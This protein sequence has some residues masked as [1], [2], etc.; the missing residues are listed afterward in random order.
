MTA[1]YPEVPG[2][3]TESPETSRAAAVEE[4]SRAATLHR[5]VADELASHPKGL[6]ADECAG[7]LKESPLAVRPRFSELVKAGKAED[8]GERRVNASGK[9]AAVWRLIG[10]PADVDTLRWIGKS[11]QRELFA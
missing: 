9:Q 5:R 11:V 4:T 6:T 8:T 2:W 3:K 1:R 7:L 10:K